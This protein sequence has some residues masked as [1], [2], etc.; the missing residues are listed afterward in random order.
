MCQ[1]KDRR[2]IQRRVDCG[3]TERP[4]DVVLGFFFFFL[5]KMLRNFDVNASGNR[6]KTFFSDSNARDE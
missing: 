5:R 6:I 1:K 3:N 4:N 2:A